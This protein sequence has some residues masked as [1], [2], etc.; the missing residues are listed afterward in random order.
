MNEF[1]KNDRQ[2]Y[3]N[4][5]RGVI[6]E[7]NEGEKFSSITLNVGHEKIRPVNLSCNKDKIN[8]IIGNFKIG[9]KVIVQFFATSK[10][11]GEKWFTFINTLG[12]EIDKHDK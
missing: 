10:K 11:V 1:V 9:D 2:K 6:C 5:I 3:Y 12:I 8:E 4:T 7:I